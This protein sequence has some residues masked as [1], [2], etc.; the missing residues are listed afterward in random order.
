MLDFHWCILR[1]DDYFLKRDR[2][3]FRNVFLDRCRDAKN[4]MRVFLS[5]QNEIVEERVCK[6]GLFTDIEYIGKK[7]KFVFAKKVTKLGALDVQLKKHA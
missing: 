4:G 5:S 2:S 1:I 7:A 3:G 6:N